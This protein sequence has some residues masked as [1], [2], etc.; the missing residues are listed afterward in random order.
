MLRYLAQ[1]RSRST[2]DMCDFSGHVA[3][4]I[5]SHHF[6]V[7]CP[8][9]QK[10]LRDCLCKVVISMRGTENHISPQLQQG[11]GQHLRTLC[12]ARHLNF[13]CRC[14]WRML[15]E[16]ALASYHMQ[17][18]QLSDRLWSIL[19]RSGRSLSKRAAVRPSPVPQA[20]VELLHALIIAII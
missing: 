14:R 15:L 16:V 17:S 7:L 9:G 20:F 5:Q 2:G 19:M 11:M 4:H 10:A 1:N 3:I 13:L 8:R 18:L 12:A 6:H